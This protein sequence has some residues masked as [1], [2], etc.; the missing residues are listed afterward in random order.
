MSELGKDTSCEQRWSGVPGLVLSPYRNMVGPVHQ[1]GHVNQQV[2]GCQDGHSQSLVPDAYIV[3]KSMLTAHVPGPLG[4]PA[5]LF[6][7]LVERP[8]DQSTNVE[9]DRQQA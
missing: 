7:K 5:K 6:I 1:V 3:G 8:E 4:L 9:K 2:D